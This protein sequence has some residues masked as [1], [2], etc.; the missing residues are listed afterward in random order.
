MNTH[1][2]NSFRFFSTD[3]NTMFTRAYRSHTCITYTYAIQVRACKHDLTK[4]ISVMSRT[5]FVDVDAECLLRRVV[6][7]LHRCIL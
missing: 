7:S 1:K 6:Y 5:W 2:A 4:H 3:C